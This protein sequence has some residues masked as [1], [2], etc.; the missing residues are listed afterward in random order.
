MRVCVLFHQEYIQAH[1]EQET[2]IPRPVVLGWVERAE[3]LGFSNRQK[4]RFINEKMVKYKE[5]ELTR[6][7]EYE[8]RQARRKA[9]TA[10][11]K[12]QEPMS[13][14]AMFASEQRRRHLVTDED[15]DEVL[16]ANS[17]DDGRD[18]EDFVGGDWQRTEHQGADE[19]EN[20]LSGD[21]DIELD[22]DEAAA[23][24]M[25]SPSA[26]RAKKQTS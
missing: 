14:A 11:K 23:L 13:L 4:V 25:F 24:Y 2:E 1:L 12:P 22:E 17:R 5:Y 3:R 6:Q 18:R 8:E 7:H 26:D 9:A 16:Y 15:R 21:K 20:V 10:S 19:R